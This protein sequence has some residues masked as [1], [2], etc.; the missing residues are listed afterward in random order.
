MSRDT[1]FKIVLVGIIVLLLLF[2]Y[3]QAVSASADPQSTRDGEVVNFDFGYCL[4]WEETS[5]VGARDGVTI[6]GRLYL[7]NVQA[8]PDSK[9]WFMSPYEFPNMFEFGLEPVEN[10][11]SIYWLENLEFRWADGMFTLGDDAFSVV[12]KSGV[13]EKV[14]DIPTAIDGWKMI[15]AGEVDPCPTILEY[16]TFLPLIISQ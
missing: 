15:Q 7:S 13:T 9:I 2:G 16:Q 1:R 11:T 5:E 12:G 14:L 10:L 4:T 3:S 6:K 8:Y